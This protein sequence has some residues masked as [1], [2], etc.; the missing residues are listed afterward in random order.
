M[1]TPTS[2]RI[3]IWII[4]IVMTIGTIGSFAVMI[5]AN[6]NNKI[7]QANYQKQ[8]DEYAKQ[9]KIATDERLK[10]LRPL[11]GYEAAAFD[12]AA[13]T[14]LESEVLVE[15]D[16]PELKANSAISINYF[17]W[18]ADGKIFD[19]TNIDGKVTPN[20]NL[21]LDG[22]IAGWTEG[23]TGKKVGSVVKLVIPTD[24]AYG[25]TA[26]QSGR[27]AGPLAFIVQI[28]ALK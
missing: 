5:L 28:I 22:V 1:A 9:Q 12:A 23:L 14:S 17:G 27:P 7:D 20:E 6:Q 3:G 21:T 16:G 10:T 25:P 13:V 24:K 2:Q 26:A 15:G 4:A 19:S 8:M 11:E 18:T